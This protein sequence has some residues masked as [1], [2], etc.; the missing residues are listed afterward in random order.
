MKDT[1][2]SKPKNSGAMKVWV[3]NLELSRNPLL[4]TLAGHSMS[5][6]CPQLTTPP[7]R[8]QDTPNLGCVST[9][10]AAYPLP[11]LIQP[12]TSLSQL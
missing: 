4:R 8:D 11:G 9:F 3:G 5:L 1:G 2:E 7:G 6:L 10:P 12:S